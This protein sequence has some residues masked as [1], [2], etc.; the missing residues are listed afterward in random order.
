MMS[1]RAIVVALALL[2]TWQLATCA[3]QELAEKHYGERVERL[4]ELADSTR[5]E[6]RALKRKAQ[7]DSARA[8]SVARLAAAMGRQTRERIVVVRD[9]FPAVTRADSARDEVIDSLAL[10]S[11][12]W[13]NAY[14]TQLEATASLRTALMQSEIVNDSLSA[15]LKDRPKPKKP[16]RLGLTVGA[17]QCIGV[18]GTQ[19]YN[20]P[21]VNASVSWRII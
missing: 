8:D 3:T 13:Q 21:C 4:L 12:R 14:T 6:N 11:T 1:W 5:I 10:E 18:N 7:A 17:G 19:V 2:M 9:S 16:S 20:G 15:A